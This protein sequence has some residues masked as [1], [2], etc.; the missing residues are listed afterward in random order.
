MKGAGL[1]RAARFAN[2]F[3]SKPPSS[4]H[5][6]FWRRSCI[7][8]VWPDSKIRSR[9]NRE[10]ISLA[11]VAPV[12]DGISSR[13]QVSFS[14]LRHTTFAQPGNSHSEWRFIREHPVWFSLFLFG[15]VA[16]TLRLAGRVQR[17]RVA[18]V[19]FVYE[20]QILHRVWKTITSVGFSGRSSSLVVSPSFGISVGR[21]IDRRYLL[22]KRRVL[23]VPSALCRELLVCMQPRSPTP[24]TGESFPARHRC[25]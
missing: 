19:Q 23:A 10:L 21:R 5:L 8:F 25:A 3:L 15:F 20:N 14:L 11:R 7:N 24:S 12:R 17:R 1:R 22:T 2:A 16:L 6:R 4:F 13:L 9:S 18:R